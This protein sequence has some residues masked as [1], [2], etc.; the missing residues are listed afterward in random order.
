[1]ATKK[2]FVSI[3]GAGPGDIGLLTLA[4][5]K[6]IELAD[7]VLFDSKVIGE[8]Q[9]LIPPHAE[10]IDLS[11]IKG[12]N[13][14]SADEVIAQLLLNLAMSGKK[15]ARLKVGDA[16]MF[17]REIG[18]VDLL[19]ANGIPYRVIPGITSAIAAPVYAGV[20]ITHREYAQSLHILT[21]SGKDGATAD[22]P[23][24][25]L[26]AMR[27]TLVFLMAAGAIADICAGLA[28]AG[29]RP[30]MPVALVENGTRPNQRRLL[31]TLAE[32]PGKLGEG[33]AHPATIL[34]VGE[35]CGLAERYDWTRHLP[36]WGR[37]LLVVG[38][39]GAPGDLADRLREAGCGVDEYAYSRTVFE[40]SPVDICRQVK[41]YT[42]IVFTS[43]QAAEAFFDELERCRFDIR[44]LADLNFAA[45]GDGTARVLT[46]TGIYPEYARDR[47]DLAAI[48]HDIDLHV[49]IGDKVLLFDSEKDV[50]LA[51]LLRNV[52]VHC[53]VAAARTVIEAQVKGDGFAERLR[54]GE[55][56][57]VALTGSDGVAVLAGLMGS[58]LPEG[59][60]VFC[61]DDAVAA[62]ARKLSLTSLVGKRPDIDGI[63]ECVIST[64]GR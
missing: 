55:Y 42:W 26:A 30:D 48:A 49:R 21:A 53:E 35:A 11:A 63:V 54:A 57:A 9:A 24:R 59:L 33:R 39:R 52:G 16:N 60:Q 64:F 2:G 44:G 56:D 38:S 10:A 61:L 15:V 51:S 34:A 46:D 5:A 19:S 8:I 12:E 58:D 28:A 6:A 3:I 13:A 37:N 43:R 23:F 40:P 17:G 20:P 41:Y 22:I 4:G 29:M 25:E 14:Q 7:A 47:Y 62:G 36:L 45:I 50:G 27:G 31:S 1:M 18:E 32:L